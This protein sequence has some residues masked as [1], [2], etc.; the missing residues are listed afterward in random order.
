MYMRAGELSGA[1]LFKSL[2]GRYLQEA[3]E[4][5]MAID[6]L[7]TLIKNTRKPAVKKTPSD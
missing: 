2:A 3:G 6:Y 5:R 1:S 7:Q 4:T